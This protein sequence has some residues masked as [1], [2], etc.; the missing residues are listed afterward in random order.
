VNPTRIPGLTIL[1]IL[2][3]AGVVPVAA[4]D[5]G[6][7]P[8]HL[9]PTTIGGDP[10]KPPETRVIYG[11]DDRIDL[12]AESDPIRKH[13]AHAV[14]ALVAN[15]QI[16]PIDS[17]TVSLAAFAYTVN[18]SPPCDGEP[19]GNQPIAAFCTGFLVGPD[20]VVTA[21][22]CID[23]T[24]VTSTSF[25]FH[26][27]MFDAFNPQLTYSTDNV[28]TGSSIVGRVWTATNDWAI[29][30][31]DRPVTA[32]GALPFKIRRTDVVQP[33]TP[34]GVIGHPA[35]L[36]L[37][38]AYGPATVV[39][40]SAPTNFF[41]ANL[42]TYGGNSGSPVI[43]AETGLV[44][45]ILVRGATDFLDGGGCFV[46]NVLP[47]DSPGEESTKITNLDH[48]I[49]PLAPMTEVYWT[50]GSVE[51]VTEGD[52]TFETPFGHI[53]VAIYRLADGGTLTARQSGTTNADPITGTFDKP[54][55]IETMDGPVRLGDSA[56]RASSRATSSTGFISR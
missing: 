47:D 7:S 53:D 50:V 27:A 26:F 8:P 2:L 30:K 36:P 24:D 52:G 48:L 42:D 32:S 38:L 6:E 28:Y 45:G 11:A 12:F 31:L 33:G 29:V 17:E 39:S 25:V 10:W 51:S 9:G 56:A 41:R 15:S 34:L 22:H 16:V 40:D 1:A 21:G 44:E 19:F 37:K 55:R 46:S 43:N 23:Q 14:C 5:E 3:V 13:L 20:L 49:P 18:G 54:M 35:G 4:S